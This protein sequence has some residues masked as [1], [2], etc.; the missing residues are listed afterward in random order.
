[1][2]IP[3]EL[4]KEHNH[5]WFIDLD[6][7]ILK[8]NGY[9]LD[10]EELLPGVEDLWAEIPPG[11]CIILTTGRE[12]QYRQVT[13]DFITSK[14]LRYD[15]AIFGL[16]LGERIVMNDPKPAG[17]ITALAWSVERNQGFDQKK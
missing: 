2:I 9:M 17:L 14:G 11:D 7:T 6:G 3:F 15:H 16:P 5:T 12:E 1:M 4:S 10:G 8:H 13:L